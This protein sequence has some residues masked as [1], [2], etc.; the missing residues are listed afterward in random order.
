[1]REQSHETRIKSQRA[2]RAVSTSRLKAFGA[3]HLAKVL[4]HEL[5]AMLSQQCHL[6]GRGWERRGGHLHARQQ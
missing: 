2:Q 6:W 1:M 3:D 4:H 5:D